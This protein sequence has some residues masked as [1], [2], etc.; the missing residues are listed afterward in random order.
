M[1]PLLAA[2]LGVEFGAGHVGRSFGMLMMF[3]PLIG[4]MPWALAR[5][6]EHTGSY[7]PGL[8]SLAMLTFAGGI[9][10]LFMRERR[11]SRTAVAASAQPLAS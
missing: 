8:A 7:S 3:L 1:W 6:Q 11:A 9:A 10:C 4:L 2:A 5:I